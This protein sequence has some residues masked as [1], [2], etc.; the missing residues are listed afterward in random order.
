MNVKYNGIIAGFLAF[1][2]SIIIFLKE[3]YSFNK[4][5]ESINWPKIECIVTKHE[6]DTIIPDFTT[7]IPTYE[8]D[9]HNNKYTNNKVAFNPDYELAIN[10]QLLNIG[11]KTIVYVNP[12]NPSESILFKTTYKHPYKVYIFFSILLFFGLYQIYNFTKIN[13]LAQR[14]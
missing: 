9:W 11:Q 4:C 12:I 3:V 1:S 7:I 2:L 6:Y 5:K 14:K 8:Y 10:A 13:I